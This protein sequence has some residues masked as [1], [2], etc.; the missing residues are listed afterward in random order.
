[1]RPKFCPKCGEPIN[2]NFKFCKK[3]GNPLPVATSASA[4]PVTPVIPVTPATPAFPDEEKTVM[5]DQSDARSMAAPIQPQAGPRQA[6]QPQPQAGPRQTAQPQ[7]RP[8]QQPVRPQPQP[9]PMPQ[10]P[11]P[12]KSGNGLQKAIIVLL[13]LLLL[14][15]CAVGGYLAYDAI[16]GDTSEGGT[17]EE[18]D[19]PGEDQSGHTYELVKGDISWEDAKKKAEEKGGYLACI[20][21]E[22]E[23]QDIIDYLEQNGGLK[24]VYIGGR[25]VSDGNWGWIDGSDFDYTDWT[26][27]EPNNSNSIESYVCL[28]N[29]DAQ[30]TW[31]WNDCPDDM[32]QNYGGQF[33]GYTAYL[34]EYD[35]KDSGDDKDSEEDSKEEE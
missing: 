15:V 2:D 19:S 32:Y 28:Y 20:S 16:V 25:L 24:V 33:S 26:P 23:E 30:G 6:A 18:P 29:L 9:R 5:L 7:P 27:G 1:M 22:E 13:I 17:G 8:Q 4:A 14:A 10:Q 12:Q 11:K 31:G 34:I 35:N 3:C 21:N